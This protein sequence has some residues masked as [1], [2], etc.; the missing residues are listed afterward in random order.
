MKVGTI[1]F[2]RSQNYGALMV[3]YS[4]LTYLRKRGI[5]AQAIDYFP[6]H[7]TSMYPLRNAAYDKFIDKYLQPFSSAEEEYDLI[8]YGADTIWE[9]YRG[10]GYDST[11][12]GADSLKA[13]RR[14]TYSA[15]G[16][17]KNFSEE[18]DE[19]FRKHLDN[20]DA[21]SVREDVLAEYLKN[22]TDKPI[23]HTCDPAF[24]L[25]EDDY[26]EVMSERLIS[27][28]YAVLYNRQLGTKLFEAAETV[29]Q[30]T[31]LRTV[32]LKGDGCLYSSDGEL[33]RTDIGP[34][35]FLSLIKYSSYVLAASFHAVAFSVIFQKQFHTIMKTGAERVE[36]LLRRLG[37]E[38][39]RIQHS[40][41]IS[42]E[43]NICYAK[44][45]SLNEYVENSEKYLDR[46]IND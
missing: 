42:F 26:L 9:Y 18:S 29:R 2:H 36:S 4:L 20:F 7:H 43:E 1:N 17:L 46:A 16:T 21:I 34:S 33:L 32:V 12:W 13:K 44:L 24:L 25:T 8:I 15:S 30:K 39:R 28:E 22:F 14:I 41:E 31:G 40:R 10:V 35:E 45:H 23:I 3:T 19:L 38:S 11:Y 37:L 27:G 5:N 6:E